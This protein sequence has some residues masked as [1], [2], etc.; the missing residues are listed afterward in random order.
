[1]ITWY[2]FGNNL[3]ANI[4]MLNN[5]KMEVISSGSKKKNMEQNYF[6]FDLTLSHFNLK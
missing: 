4:Q 3:L 5:V 2:T 6:F 1:M